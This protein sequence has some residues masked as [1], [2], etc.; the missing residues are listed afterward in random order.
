MLAF[1][2]L[3][4]YIYISWY[5]IS[6]EKK[7]WVIVGEG[8]IKDFQFAKDMCFSLGQGKTI[9]I[10]MSVCTKFKYKVKVYN[11]FLQVMKIREVLNSIE[12]PNGLYPNYLNPKTGRWGQSKYLL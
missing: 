4:G 8:Q 9:T 11:V 3:I 2:F 5:F 10:I 7:V 12:K 1:I 6:N